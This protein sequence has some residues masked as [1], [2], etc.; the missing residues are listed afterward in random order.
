[1]SIPLR[2]LIVEDRIE[3]AKLLLRELRQSGFEVDWTRVQTEGEFLSNLGSDLDVILS[4]YSMPSFDAPQA[5]N[6]LQQSGHD[7]PFIIVTGTVSEEA[8]VESM[9]R[10]A[11]DYLLKDRLGRL[12]QAVSNVL[13]AKRSRDEKR[14]TEEALRESEERYR[15]LVSNIPDVTWLADRDGKL[16]FCSANAN[17][18]YGYAP[19]ELLELTPEGA[20]SGRVDHQD[21][22]SVRKYYEALFD[23]GRPFDVEYRIRRNDEQWVW[24]HSR[25]FTTYERNGVRYAYGV[26]SDITERKRLEAQ[27]LQA[28]KME[29]VG[30]LAGGVA[31]DFNN[32]LTA[33]IGYCQ[34][35]APTFDKTDPRVEQVAE[36]ERAGKNAASL[37]R[38]LLAFSRQ[39]VMEVTV[40]DLNAVVS[41]TEKMLRR[42][43]GED[44]NL[45]ISLGSD[46]GRVKADQS[47]I[48]QV[49]MNLVVNS[50]DAM[51]SG[52]NLT[53]QTA[54]V[55]LPMEVSEQDTGIRPGAYVRLSVSDS[56]SG[57][58]PETLAHIFEPFFTTKEK[59]KG[60]GLGLSTVYGIVKQSGG[61]C[62]VHSEPGA[63]TMFS[64]FLPGV[65]E[66]ATS[67]SSTVEAKPTQHGSETILLVEDDDTVRIFTNEVL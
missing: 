62:E 39:Q 58:D 56:G 33:I 9:K 38:Q 30:R 7:I 16:A 42:V 1:M 53:I 48:T 41:D 67:F 57:I 29:A 60:T 47:Q 18:I 52:G 14:R 37:T 28:Q 17:L 27:L 19:S 36:V 23:L 22:E 13:E 55:E 59:G 66:P 24:V 43:I 20:H 65:E 25:A 4:D 21:G 54:S 64:V 8:V 50:R 6:L 45:V 3:D 5:L 61:Y 31:H 32:L 26:N 63:G 40:F 2:V 11:D 44:I 46:L 34:L 15:L 51:P 10:G 12:G 49:I 35:L